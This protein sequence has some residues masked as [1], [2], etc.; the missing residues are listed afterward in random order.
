MSLKLKLVNF[1]DAFNKVRKRIL[2][3][4]DTAGILAALTG[5]LLMIYQVGFD[6]SPERVATI[7]R[8]Y[9]LILFLVLISN[10]SGLGLK[11]WRLKTMKLRIAELIVIPL[12]IV[13]LDI[14]TGF[15]GL[16]SHDTV[17]FHL[18]SHNLAVY[19]LLILVLIIEVST[20]S[21]ALSNRSMNPALLFVISFLLI[22]VFGT[23]LLMLPTATTGGITFTDAFFTSA[24]AV[25]VTGLVVVDTATHFTP[26]GKFFILMLIQVGGLGIM[27]FTSFFGYFF[28]GGASFGNE[29]LLKELINEEKLGEIFKTLLKIV[30]ITF[31]IEGAGAFLIYSFTDMS[32]FEGR[33]DLIAFSVFHS[34]SAFCNAGF[35]TLSGGLYEP[36]F[37]YNY[38]LHYTVAFLIIAGGLGFPIVFNYYR[39]VRHYFFNLFSWLVR[40]RK[41]YHVPNIINVNTRIVLVTTVILLVSGAVFFFVAEYSHSL[42]GL[43]LRGK[44]AGSFFGSVTARTAG[45][46]TVDLMLF[47]PATILLF[48]LL[49]WIG[50]SPASTGGGIKTSTFALSVLNVISL[51]KGKDRIEI[52]GREI[53]NES[54]RRAFSVV[55]LS[56]LII[57]LA[58]LA[59]M[60]TDGSL[61]LERI[62]FEVISAF[63]TVGLTLGVTPNLSETGKWIIIVTMFIGRVGSLTLIIGLFRKVRSLQYRYSSER[64][65]IN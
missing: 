42:A 27:T 41:Y 11:R 43:S 25:C 20:S 57:S 39:L 53:S 2:T 40:R 12:I 54:V 23:G 4:F 65:L 9:N 51:A 26:L 61:G 34:V 48:F 22:I 28:K 24:S 33:T 37:R 15:P 52:F 5:F 7:Q 31:S 35:S 45:F 29:F 17:L 56:F 6:H 19:I 16:A 46:N 30:L 38:S 13:L 1:L 14:R 60:I 50:A 63:G 36:G 21:L 18:L 47:N 8:F 44:I 59:L 10:L 55:F 64:I 58:V 3:F 49:M 62:I 32:L